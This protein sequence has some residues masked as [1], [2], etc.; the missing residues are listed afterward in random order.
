MFTIRLGKQGWREG[1]D[2]GNIS[3]ALTGGGKGSHGAWLL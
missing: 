3:F 1:R 2:R